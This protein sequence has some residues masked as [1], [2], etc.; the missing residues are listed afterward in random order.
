MG[1]LA[2]RPRH[3]SGG[4]ALAVLSHQ[5]AGASRRLPPL[6]PSDRPSALPRRHLAPP[7]ALDDS[8]VVSSRNVTQDATKLYGHHDRPCIG[9]EHEN[10]NPRRTH[11]HLHRNASFYGPAQALKIRA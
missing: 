5:P 3:V 7:E 4:S 10:K 8:V 11:A 2:G 1:G 9:L 6:C